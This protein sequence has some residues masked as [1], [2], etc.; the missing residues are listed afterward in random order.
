MLTADTTVTWSLRAASNRLPSPY[1]GDALPGELQRHG[2]EKLRELG[3]NQHHLGQGQASFHLND[4]GSKCGRII[5]RKAR[6]E[7]AGREV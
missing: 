5:V 4:P 7:R 1:E 3:S 6:F 2:A